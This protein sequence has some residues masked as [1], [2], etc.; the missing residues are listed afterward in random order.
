MGR[1]L[2]SGFPDTMETRQAEPRASPLRGT[3]HCPV[4]V[5]VTTLSLFVK[6][7]SKDAG[8]HFGLDGVTVFARPESSLKRPRVG[9]EPSR[10]FYLR[11]R[12]FRNGEHDPH[13]LGVVSHKLMTV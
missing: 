8:T 5:E 7:L 9:T 3:T 10:Q 2:Y 1:N 13:R 11:H 4:P 6:Q 12:S